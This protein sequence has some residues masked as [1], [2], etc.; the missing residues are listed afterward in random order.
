MNPQLPNNCGIGTSG[1]NCR[2]VA[3]GMHG[4]DLLQGLT[5]L[6]IDL[7][8]V[9]AETNTCWCAHFPATFV[10]LRL[11]FCALGCIYRVELR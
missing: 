9:A 5:P 3:A 7:S 10:D 4:G 8:R 1:I 11:R 6:A 2:R